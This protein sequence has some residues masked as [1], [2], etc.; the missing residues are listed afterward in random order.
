MDWTIRPLWLGTLHRKRSSFLYSGGG[1]EPLDVPVTAFLLEA[2]DTRVLVDTG[3]DDPDTAHP[4]HHPFERTPEQHLSR[5]LEALSVDPGSIG[6]VILS[7]LHW[8]HAY[9][10]DLLPQARFVVQGQELRYA[11][12]PLPWHARSYDSFVIGRSPLWA[13]T[14]WDVIE[15]DRQ[16]LPGLQVLLTPGHTPGIQTVTVQCASGLYVLPSDNVPLYENW[17]GKPPAWPHIPDTHHYSLGDYH[18]TFLR[19]E[20]LGG[21]LLPPH[22]FRIFDH[23]SY[24]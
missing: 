1:P 21:R 7:H 3:C 8:D 4:D 16:L 20:N 10:L 14:T 17:Q 9:G 22:D 12:A 24:R 2:G 23:E 13:R 15:G 18:G 6:L 11:V 5:R 19:L